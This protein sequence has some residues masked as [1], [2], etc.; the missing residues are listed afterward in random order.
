MMSYSENGSTE[1]LNWKRHCS[2]AGTADER[3]R[4]GMMTECG[5]FRVGNSGGGCRRNRRGS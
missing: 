3:Y 5:L 4:M 2:A 1:T